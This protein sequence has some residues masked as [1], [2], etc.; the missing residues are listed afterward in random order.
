MSRPIA[1]DG[2]IRCSTDGSALANAAFHQHIPSTA[3]RARRS[4]STPRVIVI[5][6]NLLYP[7]VF[8]TPCVMPSPISRRIRELVD[9]N[10]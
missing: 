3:A 8:R 4:S 5:S 7:S 1:V 6:R 2:T 10:E 9:V